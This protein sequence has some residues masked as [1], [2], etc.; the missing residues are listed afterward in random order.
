M[1]KR[2]VEISQE[3]FHLTVKN[4]QLLLLRRNEATEQGQE[5]AD[6]SVQASQPRQSGA[7]SGPRWCRRDS[8]DLVASIPCED[9][10]VVLV[11]HSGTTYTHAALERLLHHG[12]VV[13]ICGRD[14]LPTGMLLPVGAHSQIVP[15]LHQ[16]IEIKQ[17]LRKQLWKQIVQAKIRA[18]AENLAPGSAVRSRLL[19]LARSV[20]SGDPSNVEAQAARSYWQAWLDDPD[21]PGPPSDFRRDAAGL[22]PNNFLNYGYAVMRAAVARAIVA[23]GLT[24]ALGIQHHRRSD[25]FCLADDLVEPLRP[26]VDDRARELFRSDQTE[27]TPANK[28][29]LLELLTL[30]VRTDDDTGPL[31]VA[32]HR[33]VASLVRCFEGTD[34]HLTIP[35]AE[36]EEC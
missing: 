36:P 23:A 33:Y 22:A 29:A 16:Q 27:L 12:A 25:A 21:R 24:P 30:R 5:P 11:E 28:A 8:P 4:D 3:P 6:P 7:R 35:V 32:L 17:P 1:I 26:L 2:T 31:M 9:T 19:N 10:G 18:Q 13:V 20:R 14:H 34:K 15:R